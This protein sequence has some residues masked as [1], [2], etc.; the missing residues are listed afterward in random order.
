MDVQRYLADEPVSACPP[1]AAYRFR[2]FARRNKT[3]LAAGGAIAAALL[4]G[5][6][7][8]TWMY[9]REREALRVASA[10]DFFIVAIAQLHAGDEA[11]YRATCKALVEVPAD[12]VDDPTR[13]R[14][15]H[16]C[17][18]APNALKDMSLVVKRAEEL[19]ADNSLEQPHAVLYALGAALYRNG[20]YDR[21]ADELEK[22]IAAYPSDPRLGFQ[23]INFQRLM[24]AMTKWQLGKKD[25]ARR[26]LV[27][28]E[29]VLDQEIQSTPYFA[30]KSA[31]EVLRREAKALI[32]P[33]KVDQAKLK[34]NPT[35]KPSEP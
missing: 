2:K 35:D 9:L 1:S 20:Q 34:E 29:P 14:Q 16:A 10:W 22:S 5:L 15:I 27:E 28:T 4:I 30:F 26:I 11:G 19:A 6:G 21:A 8:S 32:E 17:T 31:L 33:K 3:L 23:G 13:L 18:L 7:V 25:E 24:L 12:G